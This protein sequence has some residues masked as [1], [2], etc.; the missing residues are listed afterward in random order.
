MRL[1]PVSAALCSLASLALIPISPAGAATI[2]TV[3]TFDV[4]VPELPEGLAFDKVGN[5]YV[6]LIAPASEIVRITPDGD[7][8]TFAT[9]DPGTSGGFGPLGLAVDARGHVYAGVVT[10][11]RTGGVVRV[12][13]DGSITRIPGSGQIAFANGLAFDQRGT[14]YVS[15]SIGGAVWRIPRGGSATKWIEDPLLT[16]TGALGTGFPV[17]ANG[18]AVRHGSVIVANTERA[19]LV[20]IPIRPDGSAGSPS[21]MIQDPALMGADGL[22]LDARGGIYVAVIAQSTIVK[23]SGGSIATLADAGDGINQASSIA[24]GTGSRDHRDMFGVN[25]GVFSATPTPTLFT[26]PVGVPGDPLP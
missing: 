24:F 16:G 3:V 25:F 17:G 10:F 14:L 12:H 26:F 7:R 11:D 6:G 19:S 9:I 18:I 1:R 2:E 22:A 21:V 15:D 5:A 23:V 8:S 20:R 13:R 4:S